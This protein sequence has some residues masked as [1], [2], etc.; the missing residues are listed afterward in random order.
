MFGGFFWNSGNILN[1]VFYNKCIVACQKRVKGAVSKW[2]TSAQ[3]N[4]AISIFPTGWG[5]VWLNAVPKVTENRLWGQISHDNFRQN[6]MAKTLPAP[7]FP[8]L[9][10]VQRHAG[11]WPLGLKH[12][13]T[14][15]LGNAMGE[16]EKLQVVFVHLQLSQEGCSNCCGLRHTPWTPGLIYDPPFLTL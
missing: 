7:L 15:C 1:K 11:S 6:S 14:H 3:H 4:L 2:T 8:G 5:W 9:P 10:S 13:G 12:N 16:P